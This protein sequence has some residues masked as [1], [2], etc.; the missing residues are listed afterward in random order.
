M[1]HRLLGSETS[2]ES[3]CIPG[4]PCIL[5]ILQNQE[6]PMPA[7]AAA[8]LGGDEDTVLPHHFLWFS[9]PNLQ[10]Q[11]QQPPPAKGRAGLCPLQAEKVAMLNGCG[12]SECTQTAGR[13]LQEQLDRKKKE[14]GA[15]PIAQ[16]PAGS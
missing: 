12:S 16:G 5:S 6:C 15:I 11:A 10:P 8:D 2:R 9:S 14:A 1:G 4:L 3:S 7:E 13:E